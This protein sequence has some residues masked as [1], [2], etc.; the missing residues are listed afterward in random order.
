MTQTDEFMVE[1]RTDIGVAPLVAPLVL[2][3]IFIFIAFA[4]FE[5]T[6]F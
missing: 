3:L 6:K 1:T 4:K 2:S 5:R